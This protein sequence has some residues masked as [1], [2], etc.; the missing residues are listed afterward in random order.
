MPLPPFSPAPEPGDSNLDHA[1]L[2]HSLGWWV[3]PGRDD[4]DTAEYRRALERKYQREGLADPLRLA[5]ER[6]ERGR[7]STF[8]R[9]RD[10]RAMGEAGRPTEAEIRDWFEDRPLR[11]VIVLTGALGDGSQV[12]GVDVDPLSG[13]DAGPW[14]GDEVTMLASTP[15]GGVHAYHLTGGGEVVRSSAG[16]VAPGVDIRAEGGLLV[17]PSGEEA[18]PGRVWLRWGPPSPAPLV[19][20]RGRFAQVRARVQPDDPDAIPDAPPARGF[21]SACSE[22]APDGSRQR[23]SKVLIG[24]LAA[25]RALPGDAVDAAIGLLAED[26]ERAHASEVVE[27]LAEGWRDAL[28]STGRSLTFALKV[29]RAWNRLR[30]DPPWPVDKL[31]ETT[32]SQWNTALSRE[33]A[34]ASAAR[35]QVEEPE[36][37]DALEV[38]D[39][40]E[41]G[42]VE[43]VAVDEDETAG[44][45]FQPPT[46]EQIQ[47]AHETEIREAVDQLAPTLGAAFDLDAFDAVLSRAM[48]PSGVL[49]PWREVRDDGS[50]VRVTNTPNGHGFGE[51]MDD[52]IGGG[53]KPGFMAV[54]GAEAAK[55]GKTAIMD[56]WMDGILLRSVEVLAKLARKEETDEPI[57]VRY[58]LSEMNA[59]D[60]TMRQLGRWIGIDSTAFRRG[61]NG[62]KA[63]G[64]KALAALTGESA[65]SIFAR[66]KAAA[67]AEVKAG[68]LCEIRKLRRIMDARQLAGR[69]D[70][71]TGKPQDHRRGVLLLR[72]FADTIKLDVEMRATA[73]G[74]LQKRI[75]PLIFIDPIQRFQSTESEAVGALDELVE[76]LRAIADELG[77]IVFCTSDTNKESAKGPTPDR[78]GKIPEDT[79]T[80]PQI[81]AGVFRGSYKLLHLPDV[82]LV[83]RSVKDHPNQMDLLIGIN[84]WNGQTAPVR[85]DF[86]RRTGRYTPASTQLDMPNS[87]APEEDIPDAP[88]AALSASERVSVLHAAARVRGEALTQAEAEVS[89]GFERLVDQDCTPASIA[90]AIAQIVA[91]RRTQ[92][93]AVNLQLKKA[94]EKLGEETR[95]GFVASMRTLLAAPF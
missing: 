42:E 45:V 81:A 49:P 65:E 4:L 18:T 89:E 57:I 34:A 82:A 94:R 21:V 85:L 11:P 33:L 67:R 62:H 36:A 5:A 43:E 72:N 22:R 80:P 71:Q 63:P 55:V 54:V 35:V 73:W 40:H 66:Y 76:E 41:G 46:P 86:D 88:P 10:R 68:D 25:S 27:E 56:Q 32:R 9:W 64:V 8:E 60:L 12:V 7:K 74:V 53:L 70:E 38:Q 19:E 92:P 14:T 91:D 3:F 24:M 75:V 16:Q 37:E 29:L 77:A 26:A 20:I 79:R 87:T 78:N 58:D 59:E 51:V 50:V 17:A 39:D 47:Q 1:L 84:R 2:Y 13:G 90:A 69:Y 44:G 6:A 61:R 23:Q 52:I 31:E 93:A 15:R 30:A 83:L 48:I 28:E 95:E